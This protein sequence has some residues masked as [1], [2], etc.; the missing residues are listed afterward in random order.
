[1]ASNTVQYCGSCGRA[2]VGGNTRYLVTI[3]IVADFDGHIEAPESSMDRS[4]LWREIE[5]KSEREL[6]DEVYQRM[7]FV[8]CKRCR[9][10]WVKHP[11]GEV[12]EEEVP[13]TG[14][15]H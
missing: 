7:S 12:Y 15:I 1:M 10:D 11:F 4:N 8:L 5:N 3:N 13:T 2:L 6:T 14:R 9:D